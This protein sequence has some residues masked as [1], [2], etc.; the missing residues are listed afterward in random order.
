MTRAMALQSVKNKADRVDRERR[1]ATRRRFKATWG[2]A[3]PGELVR[4]KMP[5]EWFRGIKA[6]KDTEVAF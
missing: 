4:I 5:I 6:M 1:V 2:N 3:R